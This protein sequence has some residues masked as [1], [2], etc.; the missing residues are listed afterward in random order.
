MLVSDPGPN[1]VPAPSVAPS[2]VG[3]ERHSCDALNRWVRVAGTGPG[4]QRPTGEPPEKA[5]GFGLC[6]LRSPAASN[7]TRP[8]AAPPHSP[9]GD[10][11]SLLAEASQ[12][13]RQCSPW[14]STCVVTPEGT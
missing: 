5:H 11:S 2:A 14:G 12:A 10:V 8:V 4:K 9:F 7:A 6:V 13:G 1:V 3:R